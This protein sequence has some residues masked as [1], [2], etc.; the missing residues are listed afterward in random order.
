M[1]GESF[2]L[3][4]VAKVVEGYLMEHHIKESQKPTSTLR[5][6]PVHP[7]DDESDVLYMIIC[8]GVVCSN[9]KI[10]LSNNTLPSIS[11]VIGLMLS[12]MPS[13]H[14]TLHLGSKLHR[15]ITALQKKPRV[16]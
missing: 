15:W 5:T 14:D 8:D 7:K 11:V 12:R 1:F 6:Q 3:Q 16:Y 4:G 13:R 10:Y 9:W 2:F